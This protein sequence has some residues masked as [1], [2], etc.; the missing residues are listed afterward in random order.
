MTPTDAPSADRNQSCNPRNGSQYMIGI[1]ADYQ[2]MDFNS[3][4]ENA[5]SPFSLRQ[6]HGRKIT[7]PEREAWWPD[8]EALAGRI[9]IN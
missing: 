1:N 2:V 6:F 3:F 8:R 9:P 5:A 7:L 4:V